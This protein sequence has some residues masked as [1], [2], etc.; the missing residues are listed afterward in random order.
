[1]NK[2]KVKGAIIS[3]LGITCVVDKVIYAHEEKVGTDAG[4]DI[5]FIDT[6]G[7]YRHWKQ[8]YDGGE[9]TMPKPDSF[10]KDDGGIYAVD[11]ERRLIDSYGGDVTDL[12]HKYGYAI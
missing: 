11:G 6:N 10:S 2:E 4:W 12:F 5:E 1:M 3:A 7:Q 8:W 9:I